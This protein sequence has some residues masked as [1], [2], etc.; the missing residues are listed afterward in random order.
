MVWY[1]FCARFPSPKSKL[2]HLWDISP[3][4]KE[5]FGEF[6]TLRGPDYHSWILMASKYLMGCCYSLAW[7]RPQASQVANVMVQLQRS[8]PAYASED[9]S[10]SQQQ[11]SRC[12][13][14]CYRCRRRQGHKAWELGTAHRYIPVLCT[15]YS[16]NNL[17]NVMNV[18]NVS[19]RVA[20]Q[21]HHRIIPIQ[22][23]LISD[24][25]D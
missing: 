14:Q 22:T 2:S 16:I 13:R 23:I 20:D 8:A 1:W 10:A 3:A 12:W 15:L 11:R 19:I 24:I 7:Q 5:S 4:M 6:S 21:W 25:N 9:A 17:R 18:L